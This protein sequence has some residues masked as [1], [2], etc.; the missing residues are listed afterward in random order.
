M[1]D[2]Y[3]LYKF[4]KQEQN[5]IYASLIRYKIHASQ[6]V[7]IEKTYPIPGNFWQERLDHINKILYDL[8]D[9]P[10]F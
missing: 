3:K 7:D 10:D 8:F 4:N 2:V 5:V 6:M 1:G 9:E